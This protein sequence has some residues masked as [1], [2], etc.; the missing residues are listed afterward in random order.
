M[1]CAAASIEQP[2]S[3]APMAAS[4]PFCHVFRLSALSP[5]HHL[6]VRAL[7]PL[8]AQRLEHR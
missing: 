8:E 6:G 5:F 2:P 3:E 7:S 4:N 1:F